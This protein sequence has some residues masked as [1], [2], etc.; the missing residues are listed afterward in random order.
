M[1]IRKIL[2]V[3]KKLLEHRYTPAVLAV[4]A[5]AIFLPNIN[6]GF[7]LD[8]Y[9]QWSI[10]SSPSELPEQLHATGL[11]YENPGSLSTAL[12]HQFDFTIDK[13]GMKK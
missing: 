2:T 4:I 3:V 13:E 11:L 10:L 8:D 1:T 5:F 7:I 6:S 9:I 12:F